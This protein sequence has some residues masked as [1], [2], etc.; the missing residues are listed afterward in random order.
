MEHKPLSV[1]VNSAS[2][3][4]R[5]LPARVQ[6]RLLATS[7]IHVSLVPHD[8]FTDTEIASGSLSRTATLISEARAEVPN[9][10][11]F[12]NGDFLHG[13]LLGDF[14]SLAPQ[15]PNPIIEIM[16]D[17]GYDAANLGNHEFSDGTE[18][19]RRAM[20]DADF[21]I[22]SANT[23]DS[24]SGESFSRRW[25]VLN[26]L[27][28]TSDGRQIT[29][30]VGVVGVLPPQTVIWD[31]RAIN[32]A[33]QISDMVLAVEE[34]VA[35]ARADGAEIVVVLAHCGIGTDPPPPMAEHAGLAIAGLAGVDALVLGHVHL[36]FPGPYVPASG[37]VDPTEG[38]LNGTPTI[39]PGVFGSHLG[40]IDLSLVE[41]ETGW[42]VASAE[43]SLRAV[44]QRTER[45]HLIS[46]V[47]PDPQILR[48]IMPMHDATRNW[49]RRPIARTGINL[50]SYFAMVTDVPA[51][52]II[53]Q[54]QIAHVRE[55]LKGTYWSNFPIVSGTAPF[56]AGG[57][58]GPD[59]YTFVPAGQ[60][61]IRHMADLYLYPN[62]IVAIAITG[63]ELRHWLERSALAFQTVHS[64]AVDQSLFND[65]IAPFHFDTIGGVS[66][67]IDLSRPPSFEAGRPG[68]ICNLR[69][70]GE[71]VQDDQPFV[72]ATNS[73]RAS[74]SGGFF[75][76]DPGRII[77]SSDR[78]CREVLGQ[79]LE[80][81]PPAAIPSQPNWRFRPL[82]GTSVVFET[83][84]AGAAHLQDVA[85]LNL[86]PVGLTGEGF[87]QLRMA[88]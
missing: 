10:L 57:R 42:R 72:L 79:Y 53:H 64:G 17:L 21:P 81:N 29:L 74:G 70:R 16:N 43:T 1:D 86:V 48:K 40:V 60:L 30:R 24:K 27:V 3:E 87:L 45:G 22:I 4:D 82:S 76:P 31:Q 37:A 67:E 33:I 51:M 23:F 55:K 8:Y 58:A 52:Q 80:A 2:A 69:W 28:L 62:T 35:S 47:S 5:C 12:D 68:R 77:L 49:V 7:D 50:H 63:A 19:L 54:A 6:L 61:L 88:L 75:A 15:S 39:M 34:G 20:E 11:L 18:S 73:Y 78:Q 66:Y 13:G 59:N 32:G 41:A 85:H 9:C 14:I 26:R 36:P 25:V 84:P 44:A 56:K 46:Q 38:R 71:P 83:S 65:D